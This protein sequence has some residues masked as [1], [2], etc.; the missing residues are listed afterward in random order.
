MWTPVGAPAA[1]LRHALT[2]AAGSRALVRAAA[3]AHVLARRPPLVR[4]ARARPRQPLA[5]NEGE[6]QRH[7]G[8][9]KEERE[10]IHIYY[11]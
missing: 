10:N 4:A 8:R 2:S 5:H 3:C 1:R 6:R 11:M 7:G 9:D